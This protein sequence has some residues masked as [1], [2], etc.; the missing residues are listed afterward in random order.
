MSASVSILVLLSSF[1]TILFALRLTLEGAYS[2]AVFFMIAAVGL[3]MFG[4]ELW[5]RQVSSMAGE[6]H[7]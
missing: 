7:L 5:P 1:P 4:V 6:E 3:M 2:R